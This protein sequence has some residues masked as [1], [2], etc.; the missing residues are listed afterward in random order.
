MSGGS[1]KGVIGTTRSHWGGRGK[2][3]V[4]STEYGVLGREDKYILASCVHRDLALVLALMRLVLS[5]PLPFFFSLGSG[6]MIELNPIIEKEETRGQRLIVRRLERRRI[7][8]KPHAGGTTVA[9]GGATGL[10]CGLDGSGEETE[11]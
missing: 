5:Y 4:L 3:G 11:K 7:E 8:Y 6:M 10:R 2:Y 9:A 1:R